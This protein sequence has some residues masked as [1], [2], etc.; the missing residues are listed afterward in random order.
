MQIREIEVDLPE[1]FSFLGK[2]VRYEAYLG[3]EDYK[4][5]FQFM[6]WRCPQSFHCY[7][8]PYVEGIEGYCHDGT[9]LRISLLEFRDTID[10]CWRDLK[11]VLSEN[12]EDLS[13][14]SKEIG[15]RETLN[16]KCSTIV[17]KT[18]QAACCSFDRIWG[19]LKW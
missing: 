19:K 16:L 6:R 7:G 18:G 12:G 10:R 17:F 14:Y 5:L 13:K 1:K 4:K 9:T 8:N 2:V 3:F 11:T 15:N